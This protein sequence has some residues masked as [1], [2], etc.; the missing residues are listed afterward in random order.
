ME[1]FKIKHFES[2]HDGLV[3]PWYRSLSVTDAAQLL[4]KVKQALNMPSR[5]DGS[6]VLSYIYRI[7]D[8]HRNADANESDFSLQAILRDLG[9]AEPRLV[10][11]NWHWFDQ[12]DEMKFL[13]LSECFSDIWYPVADDIEIFDDSLDWILVVGHHGGIASWR[14]A[15]GGV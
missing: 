7:C 3:F 12:V 14:K 2:T 9:V 10:Y 6:E 8:R 1:Q 11:I 15:A 13:E 4:E 5:V